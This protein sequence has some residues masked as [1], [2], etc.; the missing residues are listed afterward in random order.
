MTSKELY[1][2]FKLNG[3][4]AYTSQQ[5]MIPIIMQKFKASKSDVLKCLSELKK[6]GYLYRVWISGKCETVCAS[7]YEYGCDRGQVPPTFIWQIK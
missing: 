3:Y 1:R 7:C 2:Y 5:N 6:Y 4:K